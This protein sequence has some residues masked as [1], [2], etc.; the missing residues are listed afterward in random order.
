MN[1]IAKCPTSY[2]EKCLTV[3]GCRVGDMELIK[4]KKKFFLFFLVKVWIKVIKYTRNNV[5]Y[6]NAR[7]L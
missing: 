6:L 5:Q 2:A 7:K 1:K 4:K 3:I